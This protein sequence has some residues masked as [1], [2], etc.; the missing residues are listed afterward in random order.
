MIENSK[1]YYNEDKQEKERIKA[2][3]KLNDN[4]F[5]YCHSNEGNEDI[6]RELE[7]YR[8]WIKHSSHAGKEEYE[9]K[10]KELN[11]RMDK[12]KNKL[13]KKETENIIKKII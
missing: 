5:D 10:L 11:D 7:E 3:L 4:I 12:D 2:M 1:E 6:L 8:N 13:T 9:E